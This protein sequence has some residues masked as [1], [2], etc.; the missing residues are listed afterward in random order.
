M[1][2]GMGKDKIFP[3]AFIKLRKEIPYYGVILNTLL[4]IMLLIFDA[5]TLVDMSMF[6]TLIAYFLL[7]LAVF[8]ESA[9]KIKVISLA[10]MIITGLLILF[11]VYNFIF[12]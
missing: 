12:S 1:P 6:S 3:K 10:S 11:R 4:V 9:G 2:Y 7:Y 8:K 5:K